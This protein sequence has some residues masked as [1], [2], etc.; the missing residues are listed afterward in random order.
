M[1]ILMITLRLLHI[2]FGVF[3]VGVMVFNA[4]F[5]GPSISEAGPD[6]AK[7]M[8]GLMRRHFLDIIPLAAATSILSGAWLFWKVSGGF[9]PIWL[10]SATGMTLGFGAVM[11]LTAFTIGMTVARP[12]M[13][14][15]MALGQA[16]AQAPAAER[17]AKLASAQ[18][19]RIRGAAASRLVALLLVLAVAAMAVARYL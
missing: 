1:D 15:A 2:L 11:A 17:E 14:R 13:L 19:L 10:H 7:V 8:G 12:S 5:L 18:A 4:F 3:W 16:A 6:G 9:Q